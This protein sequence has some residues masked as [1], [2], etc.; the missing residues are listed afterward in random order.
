LATHIEQ[1]CAASALYGP[2]SIL[3]RDAL[4]GDRRLPYFTGSE[5]L[6][7]RAFA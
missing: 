6:L 1:F 7:A 2:L 5:A 3:N 4:T